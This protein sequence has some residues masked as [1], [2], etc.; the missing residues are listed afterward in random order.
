MRIGIINGPNLNLLGQREPEIYGNRSFDDY[1]TDLRKLNPD[2]EISYFQS[3]VEGELINALQ[4]MSQSTDA[5]IL[6]AAGFSHTSIALADTIAAL[7]TP[8]IEVHISNIYARQAYRM[9][10]YTAARAAGVITGFGLEGYQMAIDYLN[11]T[12]NPS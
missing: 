7:S 3:N 11:R 12:T 8:V 2:V 6:N 10:S 1:L 4:E 5:I 9:H